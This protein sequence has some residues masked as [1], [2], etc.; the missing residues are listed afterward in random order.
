MLVE[1]KTLRQQTIFG[2]CVWHWL[3]IGFTETTAVCW[4]QRWTRKCESW[5]AKIF[6][7]QQ[8]S[9]SKLYIWTCSSRRDESVCGQRMSRAR[10]HPKKD[11]QG[12]NSSYPSVPDNHTNGVAVPWNRCNKLVD[13]F[14]S[15]CPTS[16]AWDSVG[17][18]SAA[19]ATDGDDP[20]W[21][22]TC[23]ESCKMYDS[24]L[25]P[26]VVVNL[27]Q[28]RWA[29]D[30]CGAVEYVGDEVNQTRSAASDQ[31]W[32]T[33]ADVQ[34]VEASGSGCLHGR[35]LPHQMGRRSTKIVCAQQSSVLL[36]ILIIAVQT[37]CFYGIHTRLPS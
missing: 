30:G 26:L 35:I 18:F 22:E 17:E 4:R 1:W 11:G 8:E 9:T 3:V 6:S 5:V 10:C 14:S 20:V 34:H 12:T 27:C 25:Y 16:D 32:L 24:D 2:E 7:R 36:N 13:K 28:F 19:S 33:L 21:L 23:L 31:F 29:C 37:L 15:D